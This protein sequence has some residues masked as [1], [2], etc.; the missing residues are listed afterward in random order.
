[1]SAISGQKTVTAAGTAEALGSQQIN[2]PLMV[3]AL[4]TNTNLVYLGNDGTPDVASGTGL[5]LQ[6]GEVV[7]FEFI[8]SLGSLYVD[9]AVNG[10]GVA[11]LALDV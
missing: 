2:A 5:P 4:T 9:A 6:A 8:G 1:M 7:I 10:E 11:W 3:K